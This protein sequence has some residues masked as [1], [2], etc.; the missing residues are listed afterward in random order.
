[1]AVNNLGLNYC[2]I[3]KE[4]LIPALGCTEPIAIAYAS[5]VC[6]RILSCMPDSVTVMASGNI[7]KNV[8][9]VVVPNCGGLKGI[10]AAAAIGITGGDDSKELEVLVGVTEQAIEEAKKVVESGLVTVKHLKSKAKLHIIVT[11]SAGDDTATVEIIHQH[12]NIVREERNGTILLSKPFSEE[13]MNTSLT[14]RSCLSVRGIVDFAEHGDISSVIPV[15]EKQIECNELISQEGLEH[16]WGVGVGRMILSHYGN[17]VESEAKAAA[18][19]GSDARMSGCLLPVVIN[20]GSGNQGITASMPVIVYAKY[21]KVSHEK[22]LRALVL[23]NLMAIHQKTR[24]GRLSAYCGAVSAACGSGA[25]ITWLKGGDEKRI[26]STI[27]N[28]LAN[29]SGIICDGAKPSCAAKIASAVDAA[30]IADSLSWENE[31]FADGE[32]IV[33]ED[34]ESTIAGVGVIAREGMQD[35][36]DEILSVMIEK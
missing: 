18:A 33:K 24:I 21:L 34:A 28:T 22:M 5:A 17:C 16:H 6:R 36:D 15:L 7:I 10:E 8:K 1:M 13:E 12:T 35:T 4:E 23:S 9:G 3:L 25:A 27:I 20:S 11:E 26:E 29:V 2:A 31:R 14:D 19:A 32:G 30:I